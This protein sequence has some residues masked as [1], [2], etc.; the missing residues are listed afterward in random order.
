MV[1]E[2]I[3]TGPL[4]RDYVLPFLF[5]FVLIFAVL[6]KTKILGD[7]KKQIDAIVSFVIAL[8]AVGFLFPAQ[9]V[10]NMIL[11]LTV[12]VTCILVF[13]LL[14]G[15]VA[16]GKDGFSAPKWLVAIFGVVIGLTFIVAVLWAAGLLP[17]IYDFIYTNPDLSGSIVANVIF[18]VIVIGVLVALVLPKRS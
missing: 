5:L 11:Y 14:Y 7:G 9:F 1:A 4:F 3:F 15:F 12:A 13:L 8:I 2:T 18:I 6:Q 17:L 10:N 16:S